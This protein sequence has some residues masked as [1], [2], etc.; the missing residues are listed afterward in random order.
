M[1]SSSG[2]LSD[3]ACNKKATCQ[4][5]SN[6]TDSL[7]SPKSKAGNDKHHT[8]SE[9]SN[10]LI[11]CSVSANSSTLEG[12]DEGDEGYNCSNKPKKLLTK[13]SLQ[14]TGPFSDKSE[15]S[16]ITSLRDVYVGA[17]SVRGDFSE[18]SMDQVESSYRR[19]G[20][21]DVVD[22]AESVKLKSGEDL[23]S[24]SA[25]CPYQSKDFVSLV[26][27]NVHQP[28]VQ[29]HL[30]GCHDGSNILVDVKVCDI[31]GD[32]GR[33]DLLAIC[34]KC[35]DGAEHIYCMHI[36]LEKVPE[37]NWMCEEC[38]SSEGIEKC[39]QSML[40]PAIGSLDFPNEICRN[41]GTS[42]TANTRTCLD[43]NGSNAKK[44]RRDNVSS[45]PQ[46]SA[47]RHAGA[48]DSAVAKKRMVVQTS[49]ESPR[50]SSNNP[51][52]DGSRA[53]ARSP[54]ISNHNSPKFPSHL[55]MSRGTLS[56]SKSFNFSNLKCEVQS[57]GQPEKNKSCGETSIIDKKTEG[58]IRKINKSVS[59]D[60]ISSRHRNVGQSKVKMLISPSSSRVHDLKS[61]K[62]AKG[63]SSIQNKRISKSDKPM[64]T[65][66]VTGSCTSP[67][68][69]GKMVSSNSQPT[70][71][72]SSGNKNLNPK[73]SRHFVNS[74]HSSKPSRHMAHEVS[75]CR[76]D[77]AVA[78]GVKRLHSSLSDVAQKPSPVI[79]D[80]S[81]E[82]R[83]KGTLRSNSFPANSR[84]ENTGATVQVIFSQSREFSNQV[85]EAH[86]GSNF[87]TT[88]EQ[89]KAGSQQGHKFK[90]TVNAGE[91]GRII[92]PRTKV[93]E[94]GE[95]EDVDQSNSKDLGPNSFHHPDASRNFA[96]PSF[97]FIW[98]GG[99]EMVRWE[100][101]PGFT[102]S[103]QAHLS[104]RVSPK[105]LEVVKKFPCNIL[106]EEVSRSSTWPTQFKQSEPSENNVALYFFAEDFESYM[107][108]YKSMV[109]Y[110]MCYDLA[111][112]GNIDELELLIFPSNL[113]PQTSQRWN[114]FFY[115]WGLFRGK[116]V[117]NAHCRTS[118]QIETA[119]PCL[120]D[121][122]LDQDYPIP[123]ASGFQNMNSSAPSSECLKMVDN[124]ECLLSS[125]N[126]KSIPSLNNAVPNQDYSIPGRNDDICKPEIS[127]PEV[128][129]PCPEQKCF[130]LRTNFDSKDRDGAV[131]FLS[132][133]T[134]EEQSNSFLKEHMFL[135]RK[136]TQCLDLNL[137]LGRKVSTGSSSGG[138]SS[139]SG[140]D[141]FP[142]S[143]NLSLGL[144]LL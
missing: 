47:K 37:G 21:H 138:S 29:S 53:N 132:I 86:E 23:A 136:D 129:L 34:S 44:I 141:E 27:P 39:K 15:P 74:S 139:G 71:V 117:D 55:P 5:S 51:P 65:S 4:C 50:F 12:S 123:G 111:L 30:A 116:K 25:K 108:E 113:L 1:E 80:S 127:Y 67:S 63:S 77:S 46:F 58:A 109:D 114:N 120:D 99:F 10:L 144:S 115:L 90:D 72:H 43:I 83:P 60:N 32:A 48:L 104:T 73:L 105:A 68:K 134:R 143:L 112:K 137:S 87:G 126:E 78:S 140:C 131:S 98:K 135:E 38:M 7:S 8:C 54:T 33:E 59:F 31:C 84:R 124:T 91:S 61:L 64:V 95:R 26:V 107:R 101:L 24:K 9:T 41:A 35:A 22:S 45:V 17:S 121:A 52:F 19:L 92:S 89:I 14:E 119:I 93:P 125:Q 118:S 94:G 11:T 76:E 106:L 69:N 40:E 110:M 18:C 3:E 62:S 57:Q 82:K 20:K 56:K 66:P 36:K 122:I 16:S 28:P 88:S 79:S 13:E 49:V 2:N 81:H 100:R 130:G 96:F 128:E 103:I 97:D 133:P 42:S 75:K 6:D 142:A 102:S 85:E 70:E